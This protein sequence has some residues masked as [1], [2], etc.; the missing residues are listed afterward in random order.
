MEHEKLRVLLVEDSPDDAEL[1]LCELAEGGLDFDSSRVESAE[2]M[3]TA[4]AGSDWDIVLSDYNLPAFN[5]PEALALLQASGKDIPF[6]IV[7]GFVGDEAAVAM[8]RA[9]AHDFVV[10]GSL[11]RLVPAINRCLFE[12]ETHRRYKLAQAA[13]QKSEARFRTLA[14]N[15][16]GMVFQLMLE[17]GALCFPY[18]SDGCQTVFGIS[19][20]ALQEQPGMLLDMILPEDRPSYLESLD[21][22]ATSLTTLGWEGRIAVGPAREVRWI[23]LRAGPRKGY[24]NA[25]IWDG[26]ATDITAAKT[27][28]IRI[29]HSEEQLRRLSAHIETLKEQ[30]RARVSREIHDDLGG[31]L[32]AI[33]MDLTGL[34]SRLP[35]RSK[36]LLAKIATI[37]RLVDHAIEASV[38]ISAGLRPGILDC[39]IVA[40]VQWQTREFQ[41]RTGIKCRLRCNQDD[42]ALSPESSVSVFRIFQE[43]LTNISKHA[44]ASAVDIELRQ[45]NG[46]FFL[47]VT[48]NGRGIAEADRAKPSSFGIRGMLERSREFGGTIKIT[49]TPGRGTKV[50]VC[51]PLVSQQTED[52]ELEHQHRLF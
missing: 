34:A 38:R 11:A 30:E 21:A 20:R 49:G 31:T 43:A 13:L 45:A 28:E 46:C 5:A 25:I 15:I 8:M 47:D 32:T 6:I 41:E 19:P 16:P 50:S 33:K 1:I 48:D 27:A 7:S 40:A 9:G 51:M 44:N 12:A 36:G 37:D 26:I 39:G 35:Q 14:A 29:R 3:Q 42:M 2:E 18:L 23:D 10:K 4:L 52:H 24:G 17:E 22:S